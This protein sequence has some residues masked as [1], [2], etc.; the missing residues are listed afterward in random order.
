MTAPSSN[1]PSSVAAEDGVPPSLFHNRNYLWLWASS[2]IAGLGDYF[3]LIA[4]PWLVLTLTGDSA[5]LGVVMALESLPRA[6]FMLVSGG[7]ADRY[8]A[9]RVLLVSRMVFMLALVVLAL[10]L[11]YGYLQLPH[12]YGFALIFGLSTAFS[13]PASRA[14]LPQVVDNT[15]IQRGNSTLMGSLQLIQ[16]FAPVLAGLLIWGMPAINSLAATTDLSRI[17]SAFAFNAVAIFFALLLL[18]R[19]RLAPA[20]AA[21]PGERIRLSD[22]FAYLW[23]DRGLRIAT[24]Y[25]GCVGFFAIGPLLTV[26]PQIAAQRLH[27][28][29]L[30]YG[31]LYAV[32]GFGSLLG[33]ALGGLLP[34]PSKRHLGPIMFAA[35]LIAGSCVLWLG[36]ST[37]FATAAPALVLIGVGASYGGLLGLSWIQERIPPRLAG[38]ILGIVM[39][40]VVGLTPVSMSLG[41]LLVAHY[42]LTALLSLS[43]C[44]IASSAMLGLLLPQINRFGAYASPA[45]SETA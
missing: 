7:F 24:F 27:D 17:A 39:F 13:M 20:N 4:M 30:S 22:G 32:N 3:T 44:A 41:G 38:R 42:S 35:D 1:Q 8:T 18:V 11:W 19:I 45:L 5:A 29:A 40:A 34:K 43:G 36:H 14:L 6:A 10:D 25:M 31:M 23:Q 16:L 28:G 2:T 21:A 26:I 12:L 9:R 15:Q 37:S 33:F